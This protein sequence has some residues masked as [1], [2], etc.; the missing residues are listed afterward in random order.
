[1]AIRIP[2]SFNRK[3][4]NGSQVEAQWGVFGFK[5]DAAIKHPSQNRPKKKRFDPA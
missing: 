5:T 1:M 4:K 3:E 2:E